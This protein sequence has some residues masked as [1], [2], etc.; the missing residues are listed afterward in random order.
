MANKYLKSIVSSTCGFISL[1]FGVSGSFIAFQLT[2]SGALTC[3]DIQ[4]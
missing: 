4:G 2:S 1:D 3:V